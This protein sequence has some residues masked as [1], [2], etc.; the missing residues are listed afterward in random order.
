MGIRPSIDI[1]HTCG[2][3]EYDEVHGVFGRVIYSPNSEYFVIRKMA[4]A[5]KYGKVLLVETDSRKVKF[6]KEMERPEFIS[7]SNIGN[8]AVCNLRGIDDDLPSEVIVFNREGKACI[9]RKSFENPNESALNQDGSLAAFA[10]VG[11]CE[12]IEGHS[13]VIFD[14]VNDRSIQITPL[15][16]SVYKMHFDGNNNLKVLQ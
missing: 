13:I 6:L 3:K 2:K 5:K 10:F 16:N 1:Y 12:Y 14:V 9:K 8:V 11:G 4:T 7:I 15:E